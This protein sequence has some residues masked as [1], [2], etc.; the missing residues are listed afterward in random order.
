MYAVVYLKSTIIKNGIEEEKVSAIYLLDYI[1]DIR[2]KGF[3]SDKLAL[4]KIAA[5]RANLDRFSET[6]LSSLIKEFTDQ[7]EREPR[8]SKGFLTG[9]H[10]ILRRKIGYTKKI[11]KEKEVKVRKKEA[12]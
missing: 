6:T 11:L 10:N 3:D 2:K 1:E 9:R 4:L 12:N 8:D 7:L 5:A